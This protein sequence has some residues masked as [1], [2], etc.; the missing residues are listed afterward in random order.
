MKFL[1]DFIPIVLFFIA[2][3]LYGVIIA[4]Y[5]AIIASGVQ[6]V[7]FYLIYKKIE[8]MY[9]IT[10]VILLVFGGFT[11]LL[12]DPIFIKWKPS[13]VYW[14]L[15]LALFASHFFKKKEPLIKKM[16]Q[17][18]FDMPN[19]QWLYLSWI[20][21]LFFVFLGALNLYIAFSFS[22]EIWVDFKLFGMAG[23]TFIFFI[24]QIVAFKKYL[25]LH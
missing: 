6:C 23:L 10:F 7:L 13:I 9:I 3:K 15:A 22:T 14:I 20:W 18:A 4:S 24:I 2:Y 25:K 16:M 11:I 12:K 17:R 5:V 19:K 21:V 8:K 1:F